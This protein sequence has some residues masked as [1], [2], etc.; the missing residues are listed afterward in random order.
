[1]AKNIPHSNTQNEQQ[2]FTLYEDI[3]RPNGFEIKNIKRNKSDV[4]H[5]KIL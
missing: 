5:V 4:C 2:V 3:P 1:M